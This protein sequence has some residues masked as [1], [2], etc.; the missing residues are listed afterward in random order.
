MADGW[1]YLGLHDAAGNVLLTL[2]DDG[3]TDPLQVRELDLGTV[4]VREQLDDNPT[5]D[6]VFD[7]TIHIGSRGISAT[8]WAV[9]NDAGGPAYWLDRLRGLMH[10]ARRCYLHL[11]AVE[12]D[13]PRR[14]LVRGASMPHGL[15]DP[16]PVQQFQWKAPGGYLEATVEATVE[17]LPNGAAS[18]GLTLPQ[19]LPAAFPAAFPAGASPFIV[20]GQVPTWA[21]ADLYGPAAGVSALTN[22]AGQTIG[23]KS[24]LSIPAGTFLR[25]DPMNATVVDDS[26]ISR[27]GWVDNS[28][29]DWRALKLQPGS[30]RL[31]FTTTGAA[32]QTKAILRFRERTI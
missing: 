22:D 26:G 18:P 9:G 8:V 25:I 16:S 27:R 32:D 15:T 30:Q 24:A 5:G 13:A 10:P 21:V 7:S 6:G 23:F 1:P 12:W 20:G 11:Q 29:L 28:T 19:T 4:D 14:V 2:T 3:D 31:T 17:L